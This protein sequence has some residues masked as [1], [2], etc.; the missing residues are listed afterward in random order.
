MAYN[1]GIRK[2]I[3][4]KTKAEVTARVAVAVCY[5]ILALP[6]IVGLYALGLYGLTGANPL[7]YDESRVLATIGATIILVLATITLGE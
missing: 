2:T 5:L 3:M 7:N 1:T 6:S 4:D